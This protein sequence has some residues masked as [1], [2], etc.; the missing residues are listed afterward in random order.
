MHQVIAE[1]Q[2]LGTLDPAAREELLE[3][4]KQTDPKLWPLVAQQVRANLAWQR[5]AGQWEKATS[6]LARAGGAGSPRPT[7]PAVQTA[8]E[9]VDGETAGSHAPAESSPRTNDFPA[10]GRRLPPPNN[11]ILPPEEAPEGDYPSTDRSAASDRVLRL[12]PPNRQ[13]A[14][15]P[16]GQ[17]VAASYDSKPGDD[18]QTHLE[19][20]IRLLE[21][22][23]AR[24]PHSDSELARQAR[25]RMLYLVGNRRDEALRPIPSLDSTMQEFWSKQ[26]YGLATLID[27]ELISDSG[28]RKAEAKQQLDEAVRKLG[29]SC[30][31]VVRNLAFATEIELFG[32]FKPFEKYEFEPGQRLL[33]YAEL[34]NFKTKE[35]PRGFHTA[36]RSSY[37][38][39]DSS[40]RR[41]AEHESPPSEEY[42]SGPRR[43]YF[44]LYD[45]CLPKRIF[46]GKH[47]LQLTVADLNS[48]KIG[49]SLIEFTVKSTDD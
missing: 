46:P 32:R 21:S 48:Q 40:G 8:I 28:H 12:P 19:E 9:P 22:D 17:V 4:L 47:V 45:L 26:L 35:T 41:V 29:E 16:A 36:T 14:E 39:F 24:A 6:V 5:Q 1:I 15:E 2:E 25:L 23:A 33:L 27:P 38:I 7:P 13:A 3:D 31:L 49:Q 43:D 37:Q 30:P 18:W 44:I 20:A 11:A 10:H 34:D 42:C